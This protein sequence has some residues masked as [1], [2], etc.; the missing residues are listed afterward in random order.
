MDLPG[1]FRPPAAPRPQVGCGAPPAA[2]GTARA[3]RVPPSAAA[4]A[5]GRSR[6]TGRRRDPPPRLRRSLRP[7]APARPL[8]GSQARP[9]SYANVST[10]RGVVFLLG[11][12]ALSP[13]AHGAS[14]EIST[15]TFAPAAGPLTITA[16]IDRDVQLG[17]R[18]SNLG[19]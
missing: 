4:G 5:R 9:R 11:A 6:D 1:T 18:L 19:G 17:V 2:A 15:R 7:A 8:P 10:V 12:L 16:Q 14:I 3:G 13:G